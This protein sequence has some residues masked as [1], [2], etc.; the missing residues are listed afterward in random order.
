MKKVLKWL[1]GLF[2]AGIILSYLA[3]NYSVNHT[4]ITEN[5]FANRLD[6]DQAKSQQQTDVREW[7][8]H[9]IQSFAKT[10][11]II[12]GGTIMIVVM[13]IP[14]GLVCLVVFFMFA[15]VSNPQNT[16]LT[17]VACGVGAIYLTNKIISK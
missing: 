11:G 16:P 1:F 5:Q 8:E 9:S 15:G 2:T 3:C 13:V 12:G 14:F 17:R 7:N 4:I 10:I 6:Y